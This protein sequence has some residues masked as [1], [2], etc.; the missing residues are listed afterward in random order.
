MAINKATLYEKFL[1]SVVQAGLSSTP[2]TAKQSMIQ[3]SGGNTVKISQI[4]ATGFGDYSRTAGYPAGTASLDWVDYT[5]PYDRGVSF[6]IDTMDQDETAGM[7]SSGNLLTEFGNNQEIPEI[8]SARYMAIFQAIVNDTTAIYGYY[9]PAIATVLSQFNTDV[10]AIRAKCGRTPKLIAFM[11]ESA[12]GILSNSTQLSKE[13]M[14]QS[15]AGENGVTTDIYKVNGVQIIP[16]PDDRLKTE[17]A[18][19]ATSIGYSA[20]AWAMD[21]N[22]ILCSPDAVVAFEKHRK[23]KVFSA[24][25]VQ[26]YDGEKIE[27][28]LYHGCWV[29]DNKHNMIYISLKTATIAGFSAAELL[30]TGLTN[31]TYTIATYASRDTGHKFYYLTTGTVAATTVPAAYD[32]MTLTSY[33]EITDA[34]AHAVSV[35][36]GYYGA[37]VEVDENGRAI[38]FETL[39]AVAP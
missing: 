11:S 9:T 28:R 14:V 38:R 27:S 20:K 21:M 17:Y 13:M 2:L 37:L 5:I 3:Y 8:D 25:V 30:T 12:F 16:V 35:T 33:T 36:S 18:F 1:D 4:T 34:A 29:L 6:L 32:K 15:V 10:S 24:D 39:K 7:L 22:W 31:I 23:L 19:A 26:G